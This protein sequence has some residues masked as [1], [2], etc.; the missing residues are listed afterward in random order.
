LLWSSREA[1]K[2]WTSTTVVAI[3]RRLVQARF[4][5]DD[6]K[7]ATH[8][9]EDICYNL[10]QTLGALDPKTLE[11]SDLLSQL[12]TATKHHREAMGVHENIIRLVTEGDDDD[13]RT[14]DTMDSPTARKQ[15]ELLKQSYLRLGKWDKSARTYKELVDALLCMP[16]YKGKPEWAG[17]QPTDKWNPKEVPSATGEFVAPKEWELIKADAL[18]EAGEMKEMP[19]GLKRPGVGLKRASSNWGMGLIHKFFHGDHEEEAQSPGLTNGKKWR[20]EVVY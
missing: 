3:G 10:R 17:V 6:A 4:L 18:T 5:A 1:Q 13:D 20:G 7:E 2:K 9:C 14:L 16:E 15:L 19:V 8:L 11:M 12:Y